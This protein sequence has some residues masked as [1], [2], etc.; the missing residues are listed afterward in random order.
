[1]STPNITSIIMLS[2]DDDSNST[3]IVYP[4]IP[5]IRKWFLNLIQF[6]TIFVEFYYTYIIVIY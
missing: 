6:N 2:S 3:S 1:M 4:I 5:L